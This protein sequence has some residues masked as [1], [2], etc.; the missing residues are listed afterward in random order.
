MKLTQ[1]EK[2]LIYELRLKEDQ[3]KPKYS[4]ILKENLYEFCENDKWFEL[5][6]ILNSSYF[7]SSE[8]DKY[9]KLFENNFQ[10]LCH[11]GTE[12]VGYQYPE[13]NDIF[14]YDCDDIGIENMP[15]KWAKKHLI[16]IKKL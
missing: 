5:M 12:F 14:W 15:N 9:I 8:K 4:G 1:K 6:N 7:S 11:E 16:N 13:S 3:N 10:I 2:E